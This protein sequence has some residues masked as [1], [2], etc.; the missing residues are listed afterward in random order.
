MTALNLIRHAH[1]LHDRVEGQGP[2]LDLG[3]SV[4][5]LA[6]AQALRSRLRKSKELREAVLISSTQRRAMETAVVVAQGFGRPFVADAEFE[7][8]RNDYGTIGAVEFTG[9]GSGC[10]NSNARFISLPSC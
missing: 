9:C 4:E 1:L 5:S 3:L 7:E 8:W 6:Q 2:W 10:L